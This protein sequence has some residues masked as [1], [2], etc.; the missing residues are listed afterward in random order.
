MTRRNKIDYLLHLMSEH[1]DAIL[2][3]EGSGLET[4]TPSEVVSLSFELAT[5]EQFNLT[6]T[7]FKTP[8]ASVNRE[9]A[10]MELSD[11]TYQA[12]FEVD[13]DENEVL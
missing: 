6:Q 4:L 9:E 1:I 12:L 3:E 11:G 10:F 8:I 5:T 13:H 7:K 2:T